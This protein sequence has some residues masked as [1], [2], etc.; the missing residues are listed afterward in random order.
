VPVNPDRTDV[1]GSAATRALLR[2]FSPRTGRWRTPTGEAWQPALAIEAVLLAYERTRDVPLLNVVEKSFARYRGRRSR[3]FDDDGWYLNVWLRAYDVTGDPKYLDE[4]RSLFETITHGWDRQCGGGVWWSADRTYKNA[5]TNELFLL[6]A[7][8][9]ARRTGLPRY[10]SWALRCWQWFDASGMINSDGLVN[11]GLDGHCRNNGQPTWTYNQG[12][13]LG[14]LVELNRITGEP[15]LLECAR[16]IATAAM[17]EL[18]HNGPSLE[19]DGKLLGTSRLVPGRGREA[20]AEPSE[21]RGLIRDG[22]SRGTVRCNGTGGSGGVSWSD[23]HC[24]SMGDGETGGH[25]RPGILRERQ[26]VVTNRDAH[27]FK[28]VLAQGLARLYTADP[29]ANRDL[30]AFLVANADAFRDRTDFGV[31]W[32]D[33]SGPVNAAS[34]MSAALL[35]NSVDLLE[36]GRRSTSSVGLADPELASLAAAERAASTIGLEAGAASGVGTGSRVRE[37]S[38]FREESHVAD[39]AG[40]GDEAFADGTAAGRTGAGGTGAGATGAGGRGGAKGRNGAVGG[41]GTDRGDVAEVRDSS[42]E[43]D[44]HSQRG[45]RWESDVGRE[46][47]VRQGSDVR[48]RTDAGDGSPRHG[49]PAA[50]L[51][52]TVDLPPVEGLRYEAEQAEL[53]G[54]GME[55]TFRGFTGTG[56]VAGWHRDGQRV[57]F[58]VTGGG[59]VTLRYA[60]GAGDAYRSILVDGVVRANGLLF[61]GTGSWSNYSTVSLDLRLTDGARLAVSLNRAG[62]DRNYLNLD[63]LTVRPSND[64]SNDARSD[65]ELT[66]DSGND[67]ESRP[68]TSMDPDQKLAQDPPTDRKPE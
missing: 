65:G 2:S 33:G 61:A 59:M 56:Y 44:V 39:Q 38:G 10:R 29:E 27:A 60:A 14:A 42:G 17:R 36:R 66:P 23:G 50:W 26:D 25:V 55:S 41:D 53:R 20:H 68:T 51:G 54:V 46:A 31:Q 48:A 6:G 3:F 12:V 34:R 30:R 63:S 37:R 24:G 21:G 18:V 19:Y 43:L 11:D 67:A 62:G 16:G 8:R 40:R 15:G 1:R 28:G 7:A 49:R 64:A 35:L 4:S 58:T 45:A 52:E 13:I 22:R 32:L 9:L 57:T 5:I 47:D